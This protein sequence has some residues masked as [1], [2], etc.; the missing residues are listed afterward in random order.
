MRKMLMALITVSLGCFLLLFGLLQ[1]TD[2]KGRELEQ[3]QPGVLDLTDWN[4]AADQVVP[5]DGQWEF[6]WNQIL[7][8]GIKPV[9]VPTFMKPRMTMLREPLPIA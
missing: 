2:N 8:P 3:S 4:F 6:Y 1:A 5:L 7:E 9:S